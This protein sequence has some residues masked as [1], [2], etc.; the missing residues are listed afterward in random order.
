MRPSRLGQLPP[1]SDFNE[2]IH[3]DLMGPLPNNEGMKYLLVMQDAFSKWIELVPLI[4]KEADTVAEAVEKEWL[5]RHGHMIQ[6]VTD[7]GKEF[8]NKTMAALCQR[9]GIQHQTTSAMHAQANGLVERTNRVV[10]AY[11]R[12]YLDGTNE[13]TSKLSS[14]QFAYNTSL[15]ASLKTT[16]YQVLYVRRPKTAASL[17]SPDDHPRYSDQAVDQRLRRKAQILRDT[18]EAEAR[19]F[20]QQKRAFDKRAKDKDFK[21]GDVVYVTRPHQGK[22]FQKFQPKFDGPMQVLQVRDNDNLLLVRED[23]KEISVHFNRAKLAPFVRQF[24]ETEAQ[25]EFEPE[26]GEED[27]EEDLPSLDDGEGDVH[28]PAAPAADPIPVTPG[29]SPSGRV[30]FD[31]RVR[32]RRYPAEE[33][34]GDASPETTPGGRWKRIR[35]RVAD[36]ADQT[37]QALS[38]GKRLTRTRAKSAG[39]KI[40]ELF[41]AKRK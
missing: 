19:A 18:F 17:F 39:I 24:V 14:L 33:S 31:P 6:M 22:Q 3:M 28:V 37:A 2:R 20:K 34:P 4:N 30:H 40:P 12:K 23:G 11:L 26:K 25:V 1:V 16:P 10:L 35:Q 32:A 41:P 8:T 9:L 5:D 27:P 21:V 15:H 7:Q 36:F 29:P 38:P 13:W